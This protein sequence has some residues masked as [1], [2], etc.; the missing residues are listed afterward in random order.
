M[1]SHLVDYSGAVPLRPLYVLLACAQKNFKSALFN[2]TFLC[3]KS[4]NV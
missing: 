1:S 3:S 2:C 4:D